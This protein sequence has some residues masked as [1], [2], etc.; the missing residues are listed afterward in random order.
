MQ[1]LSSK[2]RQ[3]AQMQECDQPLRYLSCFPG[4]LFATDIWHQSQCFLVLFTLIDKQQCRTPPNQAYYVIDTPLFH[5]RHLGFTL[6][7]TIT[8]L[9][10]YS[11]VVHSLDRCGS[12]SLV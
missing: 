4:R 11:L 1:K 9:V 12:K 5:T 10:I 7:H 2:N 3:T 8:R 6:R